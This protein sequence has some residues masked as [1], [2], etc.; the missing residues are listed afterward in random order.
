MESDP[1]DDLAIIERAE[2]APYVSYPATPRWMY[3]AFA[4]WVGAYTAAYALLEVHALLF[5]AVVV[6]LLGAIILALRWMHRWHGALPLPG[7]GTPPAEI[8]RVYRQY[9]A[10][11]A[12][13][14][15]AV[16]VLGLTAGI[17]VASVAGVL[18]SYPGLLA[19]DRAYHRAAAA[20]RERLA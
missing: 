2:A 3:P 1:R 16:V 9:F 5:L 7:R 14:V 17:A 8:T 19:F 11:I 20:V 6:G 18:L 10:G 12:V 4:L 15:V 13:L